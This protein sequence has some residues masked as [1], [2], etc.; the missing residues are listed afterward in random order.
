[1]S[2][3][4]WSSLRGPLKSIVD[5]VVDDWNSLLDDS[6]AK[7]QAY[8]AFLRENAGF[9]LV[10]RFGCVLAISQLRFGADL[11]SDFVLAHERGSLGF[12]YD[13]VEI[14]SPHTPAFTSAGRPSARL[15]EALQ[16]I[17]DWKQWI[18]V[19]RALAKQMFPSKEFQ[20]MDIASFS[21]KIFIG[22]RSDSQQYKNKLL[23]LGQESGVEIRSFDSISD[24]INIRLF[25]DLF[26]SG[27]PES[28]RLSVETRNRLANP[29]NEA[30]RG[31]AWRRL[32]TDARF[33]PY[34]MVADNAELILGE[35][36]VST[37]AEAF[38]LAWR[39]L[40]A[41]SQDAIRQAS[42]EG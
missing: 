40:P 1:M 20:L 8:Q 22:R 42:E 28:Y 15:S 34:H 19:N 24:R 38:D 32:I 12:Q 4:Y 7:E 3:Q 35:L 36:A 23:Q 18:S 26:D 21:F 13:L 25:F 10:D 5:G 9:T 37:R 2:I 39:R 14:E 31:A 27:A 16:Q 11:V 41:D 6:S 17:R 30:L 33:V 29:F